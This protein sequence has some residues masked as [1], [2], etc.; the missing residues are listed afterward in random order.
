MTQDADGSALNEDVDDSPLKEHID[1][2]PAYNDVDHSASYDH[3]DVDESPA[4]EHGFA[5]NEDVD[6][7]V[8]I[9]ETGHVCAI[10]VAR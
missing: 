8:P 4:N 5:L 2:S 9:D 10:C 6:I 1:D 3:V 7:G